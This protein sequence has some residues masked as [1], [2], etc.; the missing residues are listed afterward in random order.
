MSLY[1]GSM[2]CIASNGLTEKFLIVNVL[3]SKKETK[4]LHLTYR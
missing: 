1:L 4:V 3:M 2:Q